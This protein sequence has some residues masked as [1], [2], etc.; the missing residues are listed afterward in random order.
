MGPYDEG[1][2]KE[3]LTQHWLEC[4][5]NQGMPVDFVASSTLNKDDKEKVPFSLGLKQE[6]V[7][8]KVEKGGIPPQLSS[9][10]Y[11][12]VFYNMAKN[13]TDENTLRRWLTQGFSWNDI[14]SLVL[15][16][17]PL[18]RAVYCIDP[19]RRLCGLEAK[20][21]LPGQELVELDFSQR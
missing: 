18:N 17:P 20:M 9:S 1:F 16:N 10:S 12:D 5:A 14:E 6:D 13:L 8:S 21:L 11:E 7:K 19:E 4:L 15:L 2:R 3:M